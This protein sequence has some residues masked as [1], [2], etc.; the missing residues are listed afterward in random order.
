MN[1]STT[2]STT[3][4]SDVDLLGQL[5]RRSIGLQ[6]VTQS[7][8]TKFHGTPLQP[9]DLSFSEWLEEFEE[10]TA[11]QRLSDNEKTRLLVDHLTGP[12]REEIR[13]LP[14][15]KRHQ[16]SEVVSALQLCFGFKENTQSLSSQFHNRVQRDGESLC[17]FSRALLRTY[18]KME[19]AA[20]TQ[21]QA[22]ALGQLRD[23]SLTDQFVNGAREAW[24]RRE[25]RRI[26]LDNDGEGFAKI[27]QEALRLFQESP[28]QNQRPRA[29]EVEVE[30]A[31]LTPSPREPTLREIVQHQQTIIEELTKL[32]SDVAI[33]KKQKAP[34][35]KN[36]DEVQ[37]Y[38]CQERGHFKRD[39]PQMSNSTGSQQSEN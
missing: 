21:A 38:N 9:G 10:V 5:L 12:A 25:L 19:K 11:R 26:Q 14:E 7:R 30:V 8:L 3:R 39:C 23:T 18:G 6:S 2:D 29:R 20:E 36:M 27:R 34:K 22:Q 31:R 32:K 16:Y 35:K 24:V 13:C 17:D 4:P 28:S 37:C 15:E 1:P 33:L